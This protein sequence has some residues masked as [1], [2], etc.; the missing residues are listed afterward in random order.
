MRADV[1][2]YFCKI[3]DVAGQIS[4]SLHT[5]VLG[6]VDF[7]EKLSILKRFL[8][9]QT[10]S[11]ATFKFTDPH[12]QTKRTHPV[13]L[14]EISPFNPVFLTQAFRSFPAWKLP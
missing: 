14:N 11:T 5:S 13:L 9:V 12:F 6:R 10:N 2:D 3:T 7:F 4:L 1:G 8:L